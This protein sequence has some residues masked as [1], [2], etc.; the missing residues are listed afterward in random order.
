MRN[1]T[2]LFIILFTFALSSFAQS[3]YWG[4][5]A[6]G[7][8]N[9]S[10]TIIKTDAAG[11]NLQ[12]VYN[13]DGT[14]G[15]APEGGL[16]LASDGML[17]GVTNAGGDNQ[18]G[19]LFRFNPITLQYAPLVS[20]ELGVTGSNPVQG[21]IEVNGLLYGVTTSGGASNSGTIFEYDLYAG[22][23]NVKYSFIKNGP[24]GG[25]CMANNGRLYGTNPGSNGGIFEYTPGNSTII[26]V[27]S[28]TSGNTGI[29]TYGRLL[30]AS[31]GL[32]YGVTNSGASGGFGAIY[33]FDY[34]SNSLIVEYSFAVGGADGSS[35][36]TSLIELG[37]SGILYGTCSQGGTN[38]NGILFGF[39][40]NQSTI[41]DNF[42]FTSTN[43][44]QPV[45]ELF[46]DSFSNK[47]YGRTLNGGANANGVLFEY[48]LAT[49]N[50]SV[51]ADLKSATTGQVDYTNTLVEYIPP[52]IV[53]IDTNVCV[54][55]E[56]VDQYNNIAYVYNDTVI[57]EMHYDQTSSGVDTAYVFNLYPTKT[58]TSLDIYPTDKTLCEGDELLWEFGGIVAEPY[59]VYWVKGAL[60]FDN[61]ISQEDSLHFLGV[62]ESDIGNY[63][64]VIENE[65]DQYVTSFTLSVGLN[66]AFIEEPKSIIACEGEG[67]NLSTGV[68]GEG[69]ITYQWKKDGQPIGS[70]QNYYTMSS[71]NATHIGTYTVDASGFCG[72]MISSSPISLDMK[73][74]TTILSH[75][76]SRFVDCNNDLI[77]SVDAK[78]ENLSYQWIL[79]KTPLPNETSSILSFTPVAEVDKGN[80][81]VE[82]SGDCGV[83]V[84]STTIRIDVNPCTS[85]LYSYQENTS[86]AVYPN[87]SSGT[88]KLALEHLADLV[89]VIDAQGN[90]VDEFLPTQLLSPIHIEEKGLY[91]IRVHTNGEIITKKVII[92]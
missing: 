32:L 78:G 8:T 23:L 58:N 21:L 64:L 27:A 88:V 42:S 60:S 1:L 76:E 26:D 56:L 37:T 17:Y 24:I 80:Y 89:E 71:V 55:M 65:C 4:V 75:S 19:V 39:D 84:S 81:Y 77:L 70:N 69:N 83:P 15:T 5:S 31:N 50:L 46:F 47:L 53:T 18:V 7:G 68:I 73:A 14:T 54:G 11:V 2:S 92:D 72:P 61:V 57:S 91:L 86:I 40:I 33:S 90:K 25:L 38:A 59:D 82:V 29:D 48:D 66:T 44:A 36:Q 43:G 12:V 22:T 10:G 41:I 87:P 35:A 13:F 30:Q 45:G 9:S 85:G 16:L 3:E 34:I 28:F 62:K 6:L 74:K 79:G 20:F 67:A 49:T 63:T 51:K 52:F